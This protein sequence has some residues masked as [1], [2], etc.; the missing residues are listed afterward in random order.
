MLLRQCTVPLSAIACA[1]L[2]AACGGGGS[3]EATNPPP[4]VATTPPPVVLTGVVATGSPMVAAALK[5][6]DKRGVTVCD[7]TSGSDG[8]WRCTLPEQAQPPFVVSAVLGDLKLFSAWADAKSTNLNVTPL[9]NLLV[10]RLSPSGDPTKLAEAV[11][12]GAVEVTPTSI[13]NGVEAIVAALQPLLQAANDKVD[14]LTGPFAADGSGHDR[15]LDSLQISVRPAATGGNVEITVKTTPAAADAAPIKISFNT[16]DSAV[17]PVTAAIRLE[18]LVAEGTSLQITALADRMTRC[19]A[20]PL[21]DRVESQGTPQ[22]TLKAPACRS[23][24]VGDDPARYLHDGLRVGSGAAFSGLVADAAST[25]VRWD[26]ATFEMLRPDGGMVVSLRYTTASGNTDWS[27]V[28]VLR[29]KGALKL[30]GNQ[31][32]YLSNVQPRAMFREFVNSPAFGYRSTG[33]GFTVSNRLGTDGR[34]VFDRVEV[35]SQTGQLF[36]LKP[37]IG[38]SYLPLQRENGTLSRT[39]SI[40]LA[41]RFVDPATPGNPADKD[42]DP[43]FAVRQLSDVQLEALADQSVWRFEFFHADGRPNVVQL[44]RTLG[45]APTM[46]E[47]MKQPIAGPT[48]EAVAALRSASD[49]VTA[50]IRFLQLPT[51]SLPNQLRLTLPNAQPFWGVPEGAAAPYLVSAF[52][53][54]PTPAGGGTAVFFN[55]NLQVTSAKRSAT[56][57]CAKQSIADTHCDAEFKDSFAAGTR[58]TSIELLARTPRLLIQHLSALWILR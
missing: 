5:I 49:P 42:T 19:Y 57:V 38:L 50:G 14:P 21:A 2:L 12:A 30:V 48:A 39:N 40:M 35:T 31:F 37:A 3:G 55:D 32:D 29:E 51:G 28:H 56:V 45:R 6:V 11:A 16:R 52:G 25:G 46:S 53:F 24:F 10:A 44:V 23:L 27:V 7:T 58:L 36:V 17:P 54:G 1:G 15:V 26:R 22:A 18:D 47:V 4:A 13:K 41:A 34:P 43:L 9:T 20:L 8:T 33:Y